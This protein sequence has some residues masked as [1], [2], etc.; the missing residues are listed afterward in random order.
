MF[1]LVGGFFFFTGLAILKPAPRQ[2]DPTTML[3][4]SK[5][6]GKSIP[7]EEWCKFIFKFNQKKI[8]FILL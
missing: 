6:A 4:L 5:L 1:G 2:S 8:N 7:I 3:Y